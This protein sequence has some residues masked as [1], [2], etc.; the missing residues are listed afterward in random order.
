MFQEIVAGNLSIIGA[1]SDQKIITQWL[2]QRE[3][4]EAPVFLT[5][6]AGAPSTATW[7]V[8]EVSSLSRLLLL[9]AN[10]FFSSTGPAG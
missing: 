10:F 4:W 8:W 1:V 5:T 9:F 6:T 3:A 2:V 7:W